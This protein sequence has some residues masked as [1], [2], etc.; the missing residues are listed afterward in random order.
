MNYQSG[1]PPAST[2]CTPMA[3]GLTEK[4]EK[5]APLPGHFVPWAELAASLVAWPT[6][7]HAMVDRSPPDDSTR[8]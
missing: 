6:I 8:G 3:R 1:F 4:S 2:P 7:L 5:K